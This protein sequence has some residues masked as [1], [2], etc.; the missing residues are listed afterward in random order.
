[1]NGLVDTGYTG[2]KG[3]FVPIFEHRCKE[4]EFELA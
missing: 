2:I 4:M 1:L 3:S